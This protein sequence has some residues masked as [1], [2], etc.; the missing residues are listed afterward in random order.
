MIKQA[1]HEKITN[2]FIPSLQRQRKRSEFRLFMT[3]CGIVCCLTP[4]LVLAGINY[5]L[6]MLITIAVA[7]VA[8]FVIARWPTTGFF[9]VA[10]CVLLIEEE[11][12]QASIFTDRLYVYYWPT[13]L[14]GLFERPIGFLFLFILFVI[15]C[16]RF[17]KRETLLRGGALLAPF[18]LFFLCLA[19]GAFYGYL[20]G[21]DSKIIVVELR[22]FIYL[23]ECYLLAYNLVTSKQQIRLF[24]WM[25]IICA[26]VKALQG[27]Y[28]YHYVLHGQLTT[29]SLMSHEESF[30]FAAMLTLVF[31]L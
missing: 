28:L 14:E 7:L 21:G 1:P 13:N 25:I 16:P 8:G 18:L 2:D 24:L 9:I 6:G 12:L 5:G 19:G 10:A 29:D 20:T 23:F 27:I 15:I 17:L 26:G 31:L 11:P 30:F 3:L 22:P 4:A